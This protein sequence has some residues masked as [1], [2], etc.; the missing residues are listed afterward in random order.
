LFSRR[1]QVGLALALAVIV[2]FV[3]PW[4]LGAIANSRNGD[5]SDAFRECEPAFDQARTVDLLWRVQG[6]FPGFGEAASKGRTWTA[7]RVLTGLEECSR[8]A[9]IPPEM[10]SGAVSFFRDHSEVIVTNPRLR[11]RT[12]T[13]LHEL[14]MN[15]ELLD[16]YEVW[17]PDG[18]GLLRATAHLYVGDLDGAVELYS[19]D[20]VTYDH[21]LNNRFS[22]VALSPGCVFCLAGDFDAALSEL[23]E[24]Q[25]WP[26]AECAVR[27]G[28]LEELDAALQRAPEELAPYYRARFAAERGELEGA[29]TIIDGIDTLDGPIY[30]NTLL[31]RDVLHA[32]LLVRLERTGEAL[33]ILENVWGPMRTLS[34]QLLDYLTEP[35]L[36][37][38]LY[39]RDVYS[40]LDERRLE[41]VADGLELALAAL[42]EATGGENGET[43]SVS[44]PSD[45]R[46][47]AERLEAQI[48]RIHLRLAIEHGV[49]WDDEETEAHLAAVRRHRPEWESPEHLLAALEFFRGGILDVGDGFHE[50]IGSIPAAFRSSVH[51]GGFRGGEV[52][53]IMNHPSWT[54]EEK[55]AVIR[56]QITRISLRSRFLHLTVQIAAGQR[57]EMDVAPIREELDALRRLYD[58]QPNPNLLR[59][60]F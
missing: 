27:A 51:S 8:D 48:A 37:R 12:E 59:A 32:W 30:K 60:G 46:L 10:S 4:S 31:D 3:V 50:R 34:L 13:F 52:I 47:T 14:G 7:S 57:L 15:R 19:A 24:R 54:P 11:R 28:S 38:R 56:R 18:D 53:D 22:G 17:P 58:E 21:E 45:G 6:Y 29:L 23:R 9:P 43:E 44:N 39:D 2:L 16:L 33:Q 55:W 20:E 49:R 35:R 42:P 5:V 36:I 25:A 1:Q 26:W 40:F 41:Q